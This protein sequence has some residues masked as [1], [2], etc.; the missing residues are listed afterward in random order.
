M[1]GKRRKFLTY[2]K[3]ENEPVYAK[4]MKKLELG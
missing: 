2:V 3:R 4:L 1:V